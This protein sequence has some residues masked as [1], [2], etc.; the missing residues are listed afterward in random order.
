MKIIG[1]NEA[2]FKSISIEA[3]FFLLYTSG[4][5]IASFFF[6]M[7]HYTIHFNSVEKCFLNIK[8][9]DPPVLRKKST[10]QFFKEPKNNEEIIQ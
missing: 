10:R 7:L 2:H 8:A 4:G 1:W 5:H 6:L 9:K 3:F